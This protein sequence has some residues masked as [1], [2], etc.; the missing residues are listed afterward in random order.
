MFVLVTSGRG[1]WIFGSVLIGLV[2][3]WALDEWLLGGAAGIWLPS[4]AVAL[5]GIFCIVLGIQ[6]RFR[7]PEHVID[8]QTGRERVIRIV[9]SAYWIRAEYWGLLYL[10]LALWM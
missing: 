6:S 7:P 4:L 10:G 5:P 3:A 9:H 1:G 8:P 2:L